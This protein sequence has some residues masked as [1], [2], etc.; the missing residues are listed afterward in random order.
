MLP[1]PGS[2]DRLRLEQEALRI[3]LIALDAEHGHLPNSMYRVYMAYRTQFLEERGLMDAAPGVG[4]AWR[5]ALTDARQL[6][7]FVNDTWA[8]LIRD[9]GK[10]R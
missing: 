6:E 10:Q 1:A 9:S 8:E 4:E 2:V 3:G 5:E 7:A